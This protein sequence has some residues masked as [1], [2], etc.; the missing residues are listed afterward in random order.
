MSERPES[1]L[2]PPRGNT[3]RGA[4]N[5]APNAIWRHPETLDRTWDYDD[6]GKLLLGRWKERWY[7]WTDDR[8]IVTVAGSR[9]GKSSTVLVPNLK[10][11]PGSAIVLDPKGELTKATA[12]D[13]R[14]LGHNVFVLDPFGITSEPTASHN[15][16][17]EIG[18]LRGRD[19][20]GDAMLMSEALIITNEK[21][22][23]W[24]DAARNFIRGLSLYLKLFDPAN[25]NLETIR[26]HLHAD[27]D[28]L[29]KL[30]SKMIR[31]DAKASAEHAIIRNV[32]TSV[33]SKL[34]LAPRE[35]QSV[36]ST[37][38]E[39]TAPLDDV[40]SISK[41]SDF[42]LADLKKHPTTIYLVLPGI[43]MGTHFR[44]LRLVIQQAMAAMEFTET[45][46]GSL[47]VLFVLEEFSTLG[48][49]R[50]I[51]TAVSFMAGFGV[52]IWSVLQD[53]TQLKTHYPNSWETFLGNA[54]LIQ[55][56]ANADVTTTEHLS[57][58]MGQT[59][60]IEEQTVFV[61]GSQMGHGDSGQRENIRQARLLDPAEITKFFARETNRQL[62]IVPGEDPIYMDRLPPERRIA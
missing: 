48:H 59:T 53:F 24:T 11:Y 40:V 32:G 47:P 43:R 17:D 4:A 5:A 41:R 1:A 30:L 36:L 27:E 31:V 50:S 15:P 38:Q 6:A 28:A 29:T 8:H 14:E 46:R 25:A 13:R 60:F 51:E 2:F 49:M 20:A 10:R 35:L 3:G 7:G 42:A 56:F 16:L 45:R 34:K 52:K 57:K 39:Q 19:M 18:A 62:L 26:A 21:D 22:P 23:H 9:A 54:G 37:A 61:T 58:M 55:A 33:I 44:W 12:D